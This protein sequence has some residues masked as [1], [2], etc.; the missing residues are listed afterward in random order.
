M[1]KSK[2]INIFNTI[3]ISAILLVCGLSFVYNKETAPQILTKCSHDFDIITWLMN[4]KP[5][6]VSSF[7][8]TA[9]PFICL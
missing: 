8:G 2:L 9:I 5:T 4:K 3:I 7:G 6:D 1:Q